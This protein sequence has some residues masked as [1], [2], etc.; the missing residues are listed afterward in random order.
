MT[1]PISSST[2][3]NL[4]AV[5]G[6]FTVIELAATSGSGDDIFANIG[7]E[8]AAEFGASDPRLM[9]QPTGLLISNDHASATV[10]I[11][12]VTAASGAARGVAIT[13]GNALFLGI[14]GL[15]NSSN[16]LTYSTTG[17]ASVA[18]FY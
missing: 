6:Q 17:T 3:A 13:P 10:Y 14:V 9:M 12:S 11:N 7:V 18:V 1:R 8:I 15:P 16:G 4:P 5:N 2:I